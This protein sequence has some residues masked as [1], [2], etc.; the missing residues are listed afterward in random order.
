MNRKLL[1]ALL[2]CSAALTLAAQA[3]EATARPPGRFYVGVE[4][5]RSTADADAAPLISS[6]V[7]NPNTRTGSSSGYKIRFGMQIIQFLAVEAGYM[8]FGSVDINDVAYSCPSSRSP[9]CTYDINTKLHG[10]SISV[11]GNVP[12]G[13]RWALVARVG[14]LQAS[15]ITTL[16]DPQDPSERKRL[17][18]ANV[19]ANVGVGVRYKMSE[20]LDAEL[21]WEQSSQL[22]FGAGT[23][24]VVFN[25]G[26]A[27]L[28]SLGVRYRF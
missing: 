20:R 27:R 3:A 11:V 21:N 13:D 9:P 24:S 26:T 17:T 8:D 19:A 4:V 6:Y 18:D 7:D 5:G 10:P 15:G 28:T 23:G 1:A 12:L 14:W 22:G 2:G 16:E 25:F